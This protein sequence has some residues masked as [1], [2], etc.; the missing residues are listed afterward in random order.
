MDI[1][2]KLKGRRLRSYAEGA[3]EP[4]GSLSPRGNRRAPSD[5]SPAV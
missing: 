4:R 2:P 3:D 5:I 1:G